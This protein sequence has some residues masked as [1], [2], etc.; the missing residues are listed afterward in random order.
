MR[1]PLILTAWRPLAIGIV[2]MALAP[3]AGAQGVYKYTDP[4]GRV[5]Y[6]DDPNAG[7]GTARPVEIPASSGATAPA[8]GLSASERT[9]LEQANQRAASLD[10]AVADIVAAHAELRAAEARREQGVEPIE[11]ERQGRRYRPEYWGRQQ[12]LQRAI[13]VARANLNDAI[14][15]RNALR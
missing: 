15:R 10:R 12:A 1:V 4:S 6:T 7:G 11:G 5:I 8:A 9:L 2:L 13:D 14:E 3:A